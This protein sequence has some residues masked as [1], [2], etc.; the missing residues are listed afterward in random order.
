M[1]T[2]GKNMKWTV[3]A[4]YR[5]RIKAVFVDALGVPHFRRS[6][7]S[8]L[9]TD[10]SGVF[11]VPGGAL[12]P[13]DLARPVARDPVADPRTIAKLAEQGVEEVEYVDKAHRYF[14]VPG[15][16]YSAHAAAR[17]TTAAGF[18][19]RAI[20]RRRSAQGRTARLDCGS[21]ARSH[22]RSSRP[23]ATRP[24]R[25][26]SGAHAAVNRRS[27]CSS[28][29]SPRGERRRPALGR[30][31]R[32]TL[33]PASSLEGQ[34]HPHRPCNDI[35]LRLRAR[36]NERSRS[37]RRCRAAVTGIGV[38]PRP[39][40]AGDGSPIRPRGDV[41]RSPAAPRV[42][43][44]T[45]IGTRA[46]P[47]SATFTIQTSTGSR[48]RSKLCGLMSRW[49]P[50]TRWTSR[51]PISVC[52]ST[53]ATNCHLCRSRRKP[54]SDPPS[55]YSSRWGICVEVGLDSHDVTIVELTLEVY[56]LSL[57]PLTV[58]GRHVDQLLH[59]ELL[60][61]LPVPHQEHFPES[62]P[63]ERAHCLKAFIDRL[64]AIFFHLSPCA[65]SPG[66]VAPRKGGHHGSREHETAHDQLDVPG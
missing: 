31:L 41:A 61:C 26:D 62:A 54:S 59:G 25:R 1:A 3:D 50:F 14:A 24:P 52:I 16:R 29:H 32:P 45:V 5:E 28:P 33:G 55:Q 9:R 40:L 38:A 60:L 21:A 7:H 58:L 47:K 12:R 66:S 35:S 6:P 34:N 57:E 11:S 13:E 23:P 44:P 65:H 51:R 49:K 36:A 43:G 39:C 27:S 4:A 42:I 22:P 48:A 2:F 37:V 20:T 30:R 15:G 56:G 17:L 53:R 63:P 10:S 18:A 46:K 8:R 19:G 64:R